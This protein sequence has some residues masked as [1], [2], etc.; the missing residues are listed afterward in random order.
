MPII[1]SHRGIL[2]DDS[3]NQNN[4]KQICKILESTEYSCEIDVWFKD[5]RFYLGH[6]TADFE[7]EEQFLKNNRLWCHAKNVEALSEMAKS[8]EI[9]YFWHDQDRFTLTS[10]GY[11]WCFPNET[12]S[13][14]E[15]S[16]LVLPETCGIYDK[17]VLQSYYG[18]CT[19][20]P[21]HYN[22]IVFLE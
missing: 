20:I 8:K 18:I 7:V 22:K 5:N 4:P 10:K 12:G 9:N 3:S 19:D 17:S 14:A 21:Q 13:L 6:D 16:V 11:I 2:D 1:I 15:K